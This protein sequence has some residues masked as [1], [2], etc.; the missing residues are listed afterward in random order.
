MC[1]HALALHYEGQARGWGGGS[2][3]EDA[4]LP[5]WRS[6]PSITVKVPGDYKRPNYGEWRLDASRKTAERSSLHRVDTDPFLREAPAVTMAR[7]MRQDGDS[8]D[9]IAQTLSAL[10][11][12]S[13][14]PFMKAAGIEASFTVQYHGQTV[15]VVKLVGGG[16]ALL[17]TGE[18]VDIGEINHPNFHPNRGL[19]S[20]TAA[21]DL[22][23]EI[24]DKS[25]R[26]IAGR[27]EVAAYID[28]ISPYVPV[29][30]LS[31]SEFPDEGWV[32]DNV[33]VAEPFRRQGIATA[34]LAEASR[35]VGQPVKLSQ[36][37]FA[38]Y[39][40]DGAAWAQSQGVSVSPN[41]GW[42]HG[43]MNRWITGKTAQADSED[44]CMIAFRPPAHI[45]DALEGDTDEDYDE[46]HVTV[47]YLG[48]AADIDHN[49]LNQV[50]AEWSRR[51]PAHPAKLSGYGVFENGPER[52]L[53]ALVDMPGFE[54][55]RGDLLDKLAAVGI[56]PMRNHG[57]TPHLTLAYGEGVKAPESMPEEAKSDFQFSSVYVVY[58]GEWEE[59]P[60]TGRGAMKAAASWT[61][62][63]PNGKRLDSPEGA[64]AFEGELKDDPEPALPETTGDEVDASD[65]TGEETDL[66]DQPHDAP[67]SI[68]QEDPDLQGERME[69]EGVKQ[70]EWLNPNGGGGGKDRSNSDIA[71]AAREFLAKTALKD[72]TPAEQRMLIEEGESEG[73]VASNL[74][75]LDITGTH[76]ETLEEA[77]QMA[78]ASQDDEVWLSL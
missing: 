19:A 72:F 14:Q 50:V 11:V 66:A 10:G 18:V 70:P 12:A 62:Q 67:A 15:K 35:H 6:D 65:F 30:R 23:F 33:A 53:V 57:Y 32:V 56:Y 58:G 34:M 68:V 64:F 17:D 4:S 48:K 42:T 60:F 43:D 29:G 25:P 13:P 2:V 5:N 41:S 26:W 78:D 47:A 22:R 51:W 45:L 44:G 69:V 74:D 40:P 7:L 31:T 1:S 21:S 49:L 36:T 73:V 55:A 20:K 75:R 28:S 61:S 54:D 16:E 77:M 27:I 52:V 38:D 37:E 8:A 24:I 9:E 3:T 46:L 39:T 71:Q 63:S 59:I 76:Y